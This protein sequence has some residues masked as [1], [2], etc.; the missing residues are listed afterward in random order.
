MGYL[1]RKFSTFFK[2]KY[3]LYLKEKREGKRIVSAI[4]N[5]NHEVLQRI[6][7][8]VTRD[9]NI[10][11]ALNHQRRV[12]KLAEKAGV[13]TVALGIN[14]EYNEEKALEILEEIEDA[15]KKYMKKGMAPNLARIEIEFLIALQRKM[16]ALKAEDKGLYLGDLNTIILQTETGEGHAILTERAKLF[17][18]KNTVSNLAKIAVTWEGRRLR[19]G[20]GKLEDDEK[21][22]KR[23]LAEAEKAAKEHGEERKKS[24]RAAEKIKDRDKLLREK[25]DIIFNRIKDCFQKILGHVAGVFKN[26]YLLFKRDFLF[27]MI[28]LYLMEK[29]EEEMRQFIIAH[30]MPKAPEEEQLERTHEVKKKLT[31]G[32]RDIAQGFRILMS[33]EEKIKGKAGQELRYLKAA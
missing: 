33:E 4:I 27:I 14:V 19:K 22:I 12:E 11:V 17:F 6:P 21:H 24:Y 25:E 23:F 1:S 32:A 5:I 31:K 13:D 7:E 2:G 30:L 9:H 15:M 26:G 29:E 8:A 28:M 3:F 16:D 18:K 10:D 20:V